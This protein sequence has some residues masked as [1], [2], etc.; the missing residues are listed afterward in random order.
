MVRGGARM[1]LRLEEKRIDVDGK[2]YVLRCNMAVLDAVETA[3][4]T[5]QAVMELPVREGQAAILAAML[6]DYA[7]DM[8]WEQDWTAKKVK[9]RFPYAALLD[10][11]IM[12]LFS[13]AVV[14]ESQ[15]NIQETPTEK[16]V[17]GDDAGN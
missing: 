3:Y 9:K 10:L 8:G 15:R 2:T 14:P 11:D 16:T 12:G 7:E 5:F 6:N 13:R 4:G 17:P 1:S